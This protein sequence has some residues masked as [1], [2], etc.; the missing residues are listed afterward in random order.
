MLRHQSVKTGGAL[1]LGAGSACKDLPV[2]MAVEATGGLGEEPGAVKTKSAPS[3]Q[4]PR[5]ES[6]DGQASS[7]GLGEKTHP[8]EFCIQQKYPSKVKENKDFL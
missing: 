2:Q 7:Q 8:P 6:D 3:G 4:R 5:D 1:T